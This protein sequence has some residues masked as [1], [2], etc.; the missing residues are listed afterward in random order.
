MISIKPRFTASA[1]NGALLFSDSDTVNAYLLAFKPEDQLTV[2]IAKNTKQRSTAQNSW[3]WAGIL[4]VIA[5]ETGHSTEELHEIFKRMFLNRK[6]IE[7]RKKS[8]AMPGSTSDC[9]TV[10]FSEYIERVRAEAA[11]M[12]IRVPDADGFTW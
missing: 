11:E 1:K 5:R 10:E 4:P 12:G 7:Y 2:T 6:I 3:Y 9:T 8:I